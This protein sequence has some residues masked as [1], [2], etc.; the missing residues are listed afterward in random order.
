MTFVPSPQQQAYFDWIVDARGNVI[1]VAVAGAGK[2]TTLIQGIPLMQRHPM[3]PDWSRSIIILAFNRKMA[4]E[5]QAKV[6]D[7]DRVIANTFHGQGLYLLKDAYGRDI[8]VDDKKCAKIFDGIADQTDWSDAKRA[9]KAAVLKIVGMAKNRGFGVIHAMDDDR[10]WKKMIR[11][12]DLDNGLDVTPGAPFKLEEVIELGRTILNASNDNTKVV[13]YDDMIYLPVLKDIEVRYQKDWVLVDEA[14]DTNPM[15]RRLAEKLLK[16]K[17]GRLVAVGDP[18]QAIFGFTGADNDALEQIKDTFKAAEMPLSVTYRCP[19]AIVAEAQ[20]HVS[21]IQAHE[22]APTGVVSEIAYDEIVDMLD[23]RSQDRETAIICRYN[24][25][26]VSLCFSL[27]RQGIPAKI[28]GRDIGEGL[29]NLCQRWKT[30]DLKVLESRLEAFRER[31]MAKAIKEEDG[32]KA[33]RIDDQVGCL[34]VL[35]QRARELKKNSVD[36]LAELIRSMF[37][38]NAKDKGLITLSSVHKSKGLEWDRVFILG[39]KQIMPSP[40]AEQEW[41]YE[42]EI[43]LIYVA[44]TRAKQHLID[45]DMPPKDEE[46]RMRRAA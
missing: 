2:T 28:E 35:I 15:R 16:P 3:N 36:E 1:L 31:E 44:V 4:D 45:V 21:H 43:N 22:S 46:E 23:D 10:A 24:R 39:R 9:Y 8:E 13:D 33:D 6:A 17:W 27:I 32:A 37:E 30:N 12:F 14:Q 34:M 18:H 40:R 42:Q 11:Q 5:L 25:P 7:F 29:I 26:L 19:K 41:Q 20:Q 38:D